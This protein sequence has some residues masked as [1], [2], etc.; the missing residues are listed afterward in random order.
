M[1][2]MNLIFKFHMEFVPQFLLN[3]RPFQFR[4]TLCL[5]FDKP[6]PA[7]QSNYFIS[8]AFKL[9]LTIRFDVNEMPT[10]PLESI[11]THPPD[12]INLSVIFLHAVSVAVCA[13]SP[14]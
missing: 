7:I 9:F 3:D 10:F 1:I 13:S 14:R 5:I 2:L 12:P 4:S 6:M 11:A 8:A